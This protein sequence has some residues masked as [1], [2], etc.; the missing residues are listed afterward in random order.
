MPRAVYSRRLVAVEGLDGDF[1]YSVPL[2]FVTVVRDVDVYVG[3]PSG[4]DFRIIGDAGQTFVYLPGPTFSDFPATKYFGQ[5]RGRQVIP[6][7][8]S[9]VCRTTAAADVT[10]S[11]YELADLA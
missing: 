10:V 6:A 1:E 2:G 9:F 8:A 5:W 3:G 11:G 7:G 4:T